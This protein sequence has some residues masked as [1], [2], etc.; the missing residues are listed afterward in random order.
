MEEIKGVTPKLHVFVC[1]NDRTRIP[2]NTMPSCGPAIT[3]EEVN[4]VKK[5]IAES[6]LVHAVYCTHAKCLGYCNSTGGVVCIYPAGRFFRG[7][8]NAEEIKSIIQDELEKINHGPAQNNPTL[9][10]R[11]PDPSLPSQS[12][13][14]KDNPNALESPHKILY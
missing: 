8:K 3:F 11:V 13:S 4:E 7:V 9:R 2:G 5:W 6:G 12:P 10:A 1:T 14:T